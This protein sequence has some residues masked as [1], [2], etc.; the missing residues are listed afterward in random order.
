[1]AASEPAKSAESAL[2]A[3]DL[4]ATTSTRRN[5]PAAAMAAVASFPDTS[6][7]AD[8]P[9]GPHVSSADMA[10]I[11]PAVPAATA[12]PLTKT[13]STAHCVSHSPCDEKH[14][15]T[16]TSSEAAAPACGGGRGVSGVEWNGMEWNA[17]EWNGMEW[18]GNGRRR[19]GGSPTLLSAAHP[20]PPCDHEH[21][22]ALSTAPY[23][24]A[25]SLRSPKFAGG[26]VSA[27]LNS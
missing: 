13:L 18:N 16:S 3:H 14:V 22:S 17:M 19:T 10:R 23:A 5:P 24:C 2:L 8:G 6:A 27:R 1:V 20:P 11:A 9:P 12:A 26:L 21:A 4:D 15:V 25:T 7:S